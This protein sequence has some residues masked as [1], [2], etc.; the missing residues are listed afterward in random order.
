MHWTFSFGSDSGLSTLKWKHVLYS[1]EVPWPINTKQLKALA[2]SCSSLLSLYRFLSYPTVT[3][4]EML[5][6]LAM[7]AE[8]SSFPFYSVKLVH[9]FEA[10]LSGA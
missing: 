2:K 8:M 5:K 7:S 4:G 10:L 6:S 1:Y 3:E 9:Y